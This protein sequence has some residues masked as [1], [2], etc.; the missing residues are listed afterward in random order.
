MTTK[1][2]LHADT[3]LP[4]QSRPWWREPYVWMVIGG[5]LSAVVACIVT[6]IYIMQGPDG[7]RPRGLHRLTGWATDQVYRRCHRRGARVGPCRGEGDGRRRAGRAH[8]RRRPYDRRRTRSRAR[9]RT[10]PTTSSPSS[11]PAA[12]PTPAPSTNS[13]RIADVCA[14]REL[15][16]HVDGAYGLAALCSDIARDRFHGIERADSFGVDPHK[17]LFAPY[18]CAA[19]VYRDPMPGG[20]HPRAARRL[21]RRG[22]PWRLEPQRLRLPPVAPRPRPAAVVRPRHLRHPGVHRSGR[23]RDHYRPRLRRRG[24]GPPRVPPAAAS[25]NCRS[26]CSP[27]MA[28][29]ASSTW[30]GASD[31]PTRASSWSCPPRGRANR[32][33]ASALCTRVP[34][35]LPTDRAARRPGDVRSV[36]EPDDTGFPLRR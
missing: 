14:A 5:P 12:P 29:P 24:C 13:T 15:W 6:A 36:R 21:P 35:P 25:P 19:L 10:A 23:R 34:T 27:S 33:C 7:N 31:A 16:M 11:P 30:S 8:R 3:L 32:A 17:W 1:P 4:A 2:L 26:C 18:D 9:P 20:G 28:G 22:E